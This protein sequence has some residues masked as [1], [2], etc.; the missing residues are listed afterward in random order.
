MYDS[1]HNLSEIVISKSLYNSNSCKKNIVNN[2]QR[3]CRLEGKKEHTEN[4][5]QSRYRRSRKPGLR[6]SKDLNFTIMANSWFLYDNS[7][8]VNDPQN[9]DAVSGNPNCPQPK[10]RLCAIF[11]EVQLVNGTDRPIITGTLQAEIAAAMATKTE[12]ANVRLR[13]N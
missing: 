10:Q 12:S 4:P 9:Y 3:H 5:E 7:G 6:V 1:V 2:T 11:A 8:S 13:P